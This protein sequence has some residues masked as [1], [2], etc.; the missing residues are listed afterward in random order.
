[1]LRRSRY[2]Y[3]EER[4]GRVVALSIYN[5]INGGLAIAIMSLIGWYFKEPFIFPSLG[6]TAYLFF[7]TPLA[8]A[9]SPRNAFLGHLI[10]ALAGLGSLYLFG[11]ADTPAVIISGVTG[12]RIAA[13]ALSIS[14]TSSLMIV[15][16][17]HHPPAGATTLIIALGILRTPHEIIVLMMAVVLLTAQSFIINRLAG[18]PYPLWSPDP[19]AT[20]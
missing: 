3:L 1:M 2:I 20:S 7:A 8:P 13:A 16:R 6:P 19:D 17:A 5:F 9:S 15:F 12:Q 4:R 10:G 11:L 14:L 18:F